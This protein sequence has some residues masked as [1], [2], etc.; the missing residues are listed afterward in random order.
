[1]YILNFTCSYLLTVRYVSRRWKGIATQ[2]LYQRSMSCKDV[3]RDWVQPG[4][5]KFL[6]WVCEEKFPVTCKAEPLVIKSGD[7]DIIEWWVGLPRCSINYKNIKLAIRSGN[8]ET[9]RWLY[10]QA[11]AKDKLKIC[12]WLSS[13]NEYHDKV[14]NHVTRSKPEG[15]TDHFWKLAARWGIE[16]QMHHMYNYNEG[17]IT[18]KVWIAAAKG[19]HINIIEWLMLHDHRICIFWDEMLKAALAHPKAYEWIWGMKDHD[20][21]EMSGCEYDPSAGIFYQLIRDDR[22]ELLKW[23]ESMI[24]E[25]R[26][27]MYIWDKTFAVEIAANRNNIKILEWLHQPERL[28]PITTTDLI[29]AQ[30]GRL[31][32][33]HSS[34]TIESVKTFEW[35]NSKGYIVPDSFMYKLMTTGDL[36]ALQ[37]LRDLGLLD[38]QNKHQVGFILNVGSQRNRP[39]ILRWILEISEIEVSNR[40]IEA[41]FYEAA[42]HSGLEVLKVLH[43]VSKTPLC[44]VDA[45]QRAIVM[46]KYHKAIWMIRTVKL[47]K[48]EFPRRRILKRWNPGTTKD[49][50][51]RFLDYVFN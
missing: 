50:I 22:L 19:G 27:L 30:A 20:Q 24:R 31:Y 11:S 16:I 41:C 23:T 46:R 9:F 49:T 6:K 4:N 21:F 25:A 34:A 17:A 13:T 33:S 42:E 15:Y 47:K 44:I 43:R 10:D 26:E 1:M 29:Y 18:N 37:Q 3:Y 45:I 39:E 7:L 48:S 5:L 35:L 51:R 28:K 32:T 12:S 2:L 40:I 38:P 36:E 8:F 14:I